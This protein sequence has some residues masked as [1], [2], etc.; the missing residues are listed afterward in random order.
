MNIIKNLVLCVLLSAIITASLDSKAETSALNQDQASADNK[1]PIKPAATYQPID[2]NDPVARVDISNDKA[3]VAASGAP[4]NRKTNS[5][6]TKGEP[7]K[8]YIFGNGGLTSQIELSRSQIVLAWYVA[9][10]DADAINKS[11]KNV[12]IAQRLARS[13]LGLEGGLLVDRLM[14]GYRMREGIIEGHRITSATCMG[15]ICA[16]M[17][18]R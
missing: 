4:V 15:P 11:I 12:K 8:I 6:D 1:E 16:F 10:D 17:I 3:I 18:D 7:K 9:N 14:T 13:I 2:Q 5:T